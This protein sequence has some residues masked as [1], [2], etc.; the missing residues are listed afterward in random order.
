MNDDPTSLTDDFERFCQMAHGSP[1]RN[2]SES[3][4]GAD[5]LAAPQPN[6]RRS[7]AS[8]MRETRRRN[9]LHPNSVGANGAARLAGGSRSPNLRSGNATAGSMF[10]PAGSNRT[11]LGPS[12][13]HGFPDNYPANESRGES[14]LSPRR[15]SAMSPAGGAPSPGKLASP[16]STTAGPDLLAKEQQMGGQMANSLGWPESLASRS[17]SGSMKEGRMSSACQQLSPTLAARQTRDSLGVIRVRSF[18]RTK[19]GQVVSQGDRA[20]ITST[21]A[22]RLVDSTG[23]RRSIN[24]GWTGQHGNEPC[25]VADETPENDF[26]ELPAITTT[27]ASP[28]AYH[29]HH[30][31]THA[32]Q[33]LMQQLHQKQP[34]LSHLAPMH[35]A[36]LR[37]ISMAQNEE[38][39]AEINLALQRHRLSGSTS[40]MLRVQVIGAEQ[41]GKTSLCEQFLSSESLDDGFD[42]SECPQ[43]QRCYLQARVSPEY[44]G[45][46]QTFSIKQFRL[47]NE[48]VAGTSVCPL[49][50][51]LI[52]HTE[53][54][55]I[56][57]YKLLPFGDQVV[58]IR[59]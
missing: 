19:N 38:V 32:Q 30:H 12:P 20:V 58:N 10:H 31:P 57:L 6:M 25:L 17:R 53:P 49:H 15:Y 56:K 55:R 37:S 52:N 45:V 14:R 46:F 3:S 59:Y 23:T 11:A 51:Y 34:T 1:Q 24:T 21:P 7:R 33:Q 18:R 35:S 5:F 26:L 40:Q 28:R 44:R 41:V 39:A 8:S 48:I 2:A 42:S 13:Q 4:G 22:A 43:N 36:S 50:S 9:S 29:H 54:C 16:D 47:S 27:Q